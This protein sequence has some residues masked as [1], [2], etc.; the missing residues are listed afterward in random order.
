MN[1]FIDLLQLTKSETNT[2][3]ALEKKLNG[4]LS[5]LNTYINNNRE[6]RNSI[7]KL[8]DSSYI[9]VIEAQQ[10]EKQVDAIKVNS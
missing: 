6:I 4:M 1:L 5:L 2:P 8:L 7:F 10:L 3:N 9:N